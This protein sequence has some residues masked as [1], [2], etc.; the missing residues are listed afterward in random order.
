MVSVRA[1]A[2][3]VV[4]DQTTAHAGSNAVPYAQLSVGEQ[5]KRASVG[6]QVTH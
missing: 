6:R 1:V 3:A 4:V 5:R 2:E